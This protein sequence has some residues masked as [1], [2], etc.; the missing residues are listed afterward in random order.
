MDK[1]SSGLQ[2]ETKSATRLLHETL[3]FEM[4]CTISLCYPSGRTEEKGRLV[5]D[6]KNDQVCSRKWF[7]SLHHDGLAKAVW[8]QT[9]T[10]I[11]E[12]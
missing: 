10:S 5:D 1:A 6:Y 9:F 4:A 7:D 2:S 12:P 11:P 3:G 8:K